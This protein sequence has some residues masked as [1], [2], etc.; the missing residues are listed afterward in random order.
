MATR[1]HADYRTLNQLSRASLLHTLVCCGPLGIEELAEA[2]GLHPNTAREHLRRLHDAG[3]VLI[4]PIH[5]PTRG[6]PRMRYAALID[7][8]D[9]RRPERVKHALQ[10]ALRLS[11]MIGP[12]TAADAEISSVP[13]MT[14]RQAVDDRAVDDTERAAVAA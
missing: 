1:T 4:S 2:A 3:F 8:A 14:G 13:G 9:P 12:A 11:R 5:T 10:Q 7:P 6:R